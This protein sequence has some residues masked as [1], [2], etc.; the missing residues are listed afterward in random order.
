MI[1]IILAGGSGTRFWPRSREEAPKQLL[2]VCGPESLLQKTFL[3]LL[4]LFPP[5][6]IYLVTGES[7][8]EASYH[9]LRN[10]G[11]PPENLLVEPEGRSTA[12]AIA[13]A[14]ACLQARHPNDV[15]AVF[16]ADH[17]VGD[18]E[19]FLAALA[20]GREAARAGHLVTLGLAPRRAET[21]YGYI[22]KGEALLNLEGVF[23]ASRFTE[24]P[25]QATAEGFIKRGD[26][27]WNTGIF[28][29]RM[30]TLIEE[31]KAHLP[32]LYACLPDLAAGCG[33]RPGPSPW[34]VLTGEARTR[35]MALA[36]VSIDHG[37]LEKSRRVALVPA[38]FPWS[39][40]GAWITLEDIMDKDGRGNVV[41][42][43]TLLID[44]EDSIV[45][46]QGRLIATLGLRG[47]V[48]VDSPDALLVCS[49]ERTQDVKQ[50]AET[51]QREGRRETRTPATEEKPW[52]RFTVLE[53]G[54][55]FQV[56]RLEVAPG[57]R[58]SLQSHQHHSETWTVIQGTAEV[59][60]EN[61][62]L[63]LASGEALL[64]AAGQKHRLSNPGDALLVLIEVQIGPRLDE[65]DIQR[66]ED[67]YGRA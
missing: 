59:I 2:P 30:D 45:Q 51:L 22:Q 28:L 5:A 25:D 31:L 11:F 1:G 15:M 50:V 33:Q 64:I 61:E 63:Q 48:V 44:T 60:R 58:L 37:L 10:L 55:G 40:L 56:K 3:R 7:H 4:P 18:P 12:P 62:T 27:F 13:Y 6:K 20:R 16:P 14:A 36:P 26:Y 39:D 67:K 34:R 35:F 54:P 21:G 19:P 8:A 41:S 23:H 47:L 42:G 38:E 9:Q 46:G 24:K 49:K 32:D 65:P 57:E 17:H 53:R 52:G 29:W 66:Y 43:D